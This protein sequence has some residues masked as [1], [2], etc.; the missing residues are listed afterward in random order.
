[1]RDLEIF[2]KKRVADL[3]FQAESQVIIGKDPGDQPA[4]LPVDLGGYPL[5]E[6]D[7]PGFSQPFFFPVREGPAGAEDI[8]I[9]TDAGMEGSDHN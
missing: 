3:A 1:M 2:K 7:R 5:R 9:F 6:D 8:D 4:A